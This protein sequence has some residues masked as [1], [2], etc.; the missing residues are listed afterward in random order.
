MKINLKDRI[1]K[2]RDQNQAV[3]K[4]S[5]KENFKRIFTSEEH[6]K[7]LKQGS[8]SSVMTVIFLAVVV[9][10]NLIVAELP[11]S[12][13]QIDVSTQKLYTI[14]DDTKEMVKNLDQDVTLYY[15]VRSSSVNDTVE[16]LLERYKDLSDHLKV[17]QKDPDL[18]PRLASEYTDSAV[19]DGSVIAVC[20]DK[21]KIVSYS[22]M[23][24]SSMDYSTYSTT[25]TGFD[26]EGQITS[27][28]SY[29][30]SDTSAKMYLVTGHGELT[31]SEIS[32]NLTD[33]IEKANMETEELAIMTD[34]IPEDA[35]CIAILS[36]TTDF[37]EDE[38]AK[39]I[40]YLENGG[41]AIIFSDYIGVDMPNFDSI[42]ENYGVKRSD[43]VVVE[44]DSQHYYPQYP[45]YLLPEI[46]SSGITS[47]AGVNYVMMPIAQAILPIENYRDTITIN[48]LLKS[49]D[50]SYIET[51]VQNSTWSKSDDSE[52]GAYDVAVQITETVDD[53]ETEIIYFSSSGILMSQIDATVS[54]S[55]SKLVSSALNSMC[56]V[57]ESA[58]SIPSKSL[59]YSSLVFTQGEVN[60][61]SIVTIAV[62]PVLILA[63][64]FGIWMKRR[65]Q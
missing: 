17:E 30:T 48:S 28:I 44:T 45:Y 42:L 11:S 59:S 16:K 34:E 1:E 51:D 53:K 12:V 65:K 26:G 43:G 33:A 55:N 25:T 37:S 62:I 52:T 40:S 10:V 27:A 5:A 20:G 14:S 23:W 63:V 6:R 58:V 54:G 38:A 31:M 13:K 39:V 35:S 50:E 64:G 61:W 41:K 49:T 22:D 46:Q 2:K 56:E 9:V 19:A 24:E 4:K 21:S 57:E 29:V 32:E 3:K 47:N 18:Y 8:Y 7:T 15:Y 60:F 36:P